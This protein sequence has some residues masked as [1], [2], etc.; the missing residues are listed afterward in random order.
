MARTA[1][2]IPLHRPIAA[3]NGVVVVQV[4]RNCLVLRLLAG[5]VN[6]WLTHVSHIM[7][8]LS[9]ARARRLI[10]VL[11]SEVMIT[12]ISRTLHVSFVTA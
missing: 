11:E 12:P 3:V 9:I 2:L 10:E 7:T 4:L 5:V 6:E 8:I 1:L